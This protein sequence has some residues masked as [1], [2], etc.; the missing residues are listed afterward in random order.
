MAETLR[1]MVETFGLKR[2]AFVWMDLN[3]RATGDALILVV[4]T[5]LLILV[6][7]GSRLLGPPPASR[8]W[9]SCSGRC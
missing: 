2:E 4:V 8:A 3:D 7:F 9:R 5:R 1:R 6:G